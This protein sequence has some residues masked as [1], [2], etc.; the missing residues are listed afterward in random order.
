M[1]RQLRRAQ[2][3]LLLKYRTLRTLAYPLVSSFIMSLFRSSVTRCIPRTALSRA[4]FRYYSSVQSLISSESFPAPHCGTI[5]VLKLDRPEARN[6]ISRRLLAD[7]KAEIDNLNL[8]PLNGGPAD[9]SAV[10][11]LILTSNVDGCFCAGA[12]LKERIS[13][14]FDE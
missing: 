12:D 5:K 10:R 13:F 4:Q 6:A 11:A 7:L 3:L 1:H 8:F 2:L 14:S 9:N